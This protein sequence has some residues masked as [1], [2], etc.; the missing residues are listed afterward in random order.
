VDQI[1][2]KIFKVGFNPLVY[3]DSGLKAR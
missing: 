3:K 1:A 2:P